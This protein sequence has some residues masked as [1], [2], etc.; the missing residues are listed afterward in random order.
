MRTR[1]LQ[2]DK[3]VDA[4]EKFAQ[5]TRLQ[6]ERH[7]KYY[8]SFFSA[9]KIDPSLVYAYV[10]Q[11]VKDY[12][13][14]GSLIAFASDGDYIIDKQPVISQAMFERRQMIEEESDKTLTEDTSMQFNSETADRLQG[15]MVTRYLSIV[16]DLVQ[17]KNTKKLQCKFEDCDGNMQFLDDNVQVVE[18][19]LY[20]VSLLENTYD[21]NFDAATDQY[22]IPHSIFEK[23][24]KAELYD[25]VMLDGFMAFERQCLMLTVDQLKVVKKFY[26]DSDDPLT[27]K[28]DDVQKTDEVL[29]QQIP[30]LGQERRMSAIKSAMIESSKEVFQNDEEP[31]DQEIYDKQLRVEISSIFDNYDIENLSKAVLKMDAFVAIDRL[32]LLGYQIDLVDEDSEGNANDKLYDFLYEKKIQYSTLNMFFSHKW[33]IT[34]K[35]ATE[36]LDWEKTFN[37]IVGMDLRISKSTGYFSEG[38]GDANG[39]LLSMTKKNYVKLVADKDLERIF[40]GAP[41]SYELL[42]QV[43]HFYHNETTIYEELPDDVKESIEKAK[44]ERYFKKSE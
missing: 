44:L 29:E 41:D 32:N 25:S 16:E 13:K 27:V 19:Y 36:K 28:I 10:L 43:Q 9:A 15:T 12:P 5:K 6:K 14:I 34:N 42:K 23:E 22:A 18:L 4:E 30:V 7:L 20:P 26:E 17:Q 39:Y 38:N 31:T 40:P 35:S 11:D 24:L 33:Y 8:N 3:V 21:R 1:K 2:A 37:S